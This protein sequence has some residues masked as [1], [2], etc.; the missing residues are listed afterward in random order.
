M[1]CIVALL[2]GPTLDA[3]TLSTDEQIAL[4]SADEH[5]HDCWRRNATAKIC[6][7]DEENGY[8][9]EI[10]KL[11]APQSP[12]AQ[13]DWEAWQVARRDAKTAKD[14]WAIFN[15]QTLNQGK[16][17]AYL[18]EQ[19]LSG[20]CNPQ[21]IDFSMRGVGAK[22]AD[23][24]EKE[25]LQFARNVWLAMQGDYQAQMNV[26]DCFYSSCA[27]VVKHDFM[28]YCTWYLIAISSDSPEV[29]ES[30]ITSYSTNC[31]KKIH[32][33]MKDEFRQTASKLFSVI[34][35]RP[36]PPMPSMRGFF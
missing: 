23:I 4:K 24:C 8:W 15:Q 16:A 2:C 14:A 13:A 33:N 31:D 26:A 6:M 30:E 29:N 19:M 20:K 12:T 1:A 25:K 18:S 28:T 17:H 10:M 9:D 36:L 7:L 35:H 11:K 3:R 32:P 34:Y 5:L 21:K 22:A 27:G